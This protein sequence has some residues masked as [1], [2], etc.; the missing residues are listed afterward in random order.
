MYI[1]GEIKKMEQPIEQT[2]V[3]TC[4][5]KKF[6]LSGYKINRLGVRNKT[7]IECYNRQTVRRCPHNKQKNSCFSCNAEQALF[8]RVVCR[9]NTALGNRMGKTTE[10]ILGC[11]RKTYYEYIQNK[12]T[13]DM[14]YD[15]MNELHIDHVIPLGA[16]GKD[17]KP[18]LEEKIERLHYT[19]TQILY[20]NDNFKKG[21][22]LVITQ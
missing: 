22:R 1:Y 3:C 20:A 11:D 6:Y 14:S 19:N 5:R 21:K 9:I 13:G 17:G 15:K 18:T 10:E 8:T 12:F 4:C 7:C 2:F 16:P